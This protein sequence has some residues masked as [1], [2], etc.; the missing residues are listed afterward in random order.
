M[1]VG[2]HTCLLDELHSL[3]LRQSFL[4]ADKS[5]GNILCD[6]ALEEGGLLLHKP[7]LASQPIGVEIGDIVV[8]EDNLP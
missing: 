6:R 4:F 1:C 2:S 8:V 3:F 7:E 5:F